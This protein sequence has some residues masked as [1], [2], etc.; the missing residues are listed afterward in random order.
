MTKK[1]HPTPIE[2]LAPA[3]DAATAFEAIKHGA[4]AI[5]MGAPSHG[6]RA[7]AAN[8][9]DDIRRVVDFAHQFGAKVYIT[10]NTI[11]YNDE[12]ADVERMI[13]RLYN[14]GVD[15][16]IVQDMALLRMVIP[17]IALHASTQCDIRTPEKARFLADVGFSQLVIAR[18]LSLDETAAIHAATP[19]P[20]EAFVHGALCVSY[21]GDC[22]AGFATMRRS[23]NRGECPQICRHKFDLTDNLGNVIIAG[24]HLLSLRDLNR[25]TNLAAMM[26]AG[27]SSFKIEGRLKDPAYVKN[28]VGSYRRMLDAII[29]ANPD[30]Y[31]RASYGKSSLRFKPD[32]AK[33]FNRGFTDYFTIGTNPKHKMS[34]PDTPKW[35][36]LPVGKVIKTNGNKIKAS[37][38][39]EIA[40]GDGLGY[41]DA[42]GNFNGFR[43]NR[44]EGSTI[45]AAQPVNIA[46]GTRLF[47]NNDRR[48]AALLAEETAT[49]TIDID[50]VLRQTPWG[51]ALDI[52]DHHGHSATATMPLTLEK[53]KSPQ[54]QGR[55]DILTRTGDTIFRVENV[56]DRLA[57]YFIPRSQLADLR[58]RAIEALERQMRATYRQELRRPETTGTSLP[59]VDLTYH[60]NVAN[61][62]ARQFYT[63]H[64][65]RSIEPAMETETPGESNQSRRVMTTRFCLRREYGRCLKTPAGSE[66]PRDLYLQSGPLKF[67]LQFDCPNCRMNLINFSQ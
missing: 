46:P 19:V 48:L 54:L 15:A 4:D 32:P 2:L 13:R 39:A 52:A 18:E 9:I 6:A 63:D 25:S 38:T 16:L 62:L 49:R 44:V 33:S 41:F 28:V 55:L 53:A 30:R 23:A 47:R 21:S 1:P 42:K 59:Y 64:G 45:L 5:Y 57:D 10:V 34:S 29:D 31:V 58:R 51:V 43:A 3:K 66:W 67:K 11:I 27:I 40:N 56:D 65:A 26:D 61:D 50:L 60:D 8:T 7:A 37:L 35:I 24:K 20:L 14:A 22:Q 17:P 12:I 36:G